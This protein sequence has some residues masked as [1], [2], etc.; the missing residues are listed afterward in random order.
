MKC[1][2]LRELRE[3]ADSLRTLILA[4]ES[5]R[6]QSLAELA[7]IQRDFA[8]VDSQIN[9]ILRLRKEIAGK[10]STI[11]DQVAVIERQQ[12]TLDQQAATLAGQQS[13]LDQQDARINALD[14]AAEETDVEK[15]VAKRVVQFG[16]QRA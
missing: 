2:E 16:I 14:A 11:A 12:V 6:E 9:D 5:T 3:R 8:E 10:Q 7:A 15:E 4:G 13:V 1:P